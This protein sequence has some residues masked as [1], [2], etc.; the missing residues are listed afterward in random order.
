MVGS[1][2]QALDNVFLGN[3]GQVADT[4]ASFTKQH[5]YSDD[6]RKF[7]QRFK[8]D[9]LFKQIPGRK[10]KSFP[11][12]QCEMKQIKRPGDL[13]ARL[14]KYTEKLDRQTEAKQ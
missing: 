5:D 1:L 8:T 3:L 12:Y 13:K 4:T 10:Y 9:D 6:V 11:T 2:G 7:V 14:L